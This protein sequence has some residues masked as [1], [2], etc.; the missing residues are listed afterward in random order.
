MGVP[1]GGS[2]FSTTFPWAFA[3]YTLPVQHFRLSA[4]VAYYVA[5]ARDPTDFH[6]CLSKVSGN[7]A[8]K[9]SIYQLSRV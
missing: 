6:S 4:V 7:N 5:L 9:G 8:Y 1:E 2:K 3:P